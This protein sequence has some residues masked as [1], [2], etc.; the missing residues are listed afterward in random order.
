MEPDRF[1][2]APLLKAFS[3]RPSFDNEL[4]P[5]PCKT[6]GVTASKPMRLQMKL[7]P[8]K[9]CLSF[10]Y[11]W[12]WGISRDAPPPPPEFVRMD[13]WTFARSYTDVITKFSR[14]DG[15]PIFLTHG[16]S[17]VRFAHWSFAKMFF[18]LK[19]T[20]MLK[21]SG[22]WL[23]KNRLLWAHNFLQPSVCFL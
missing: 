2:N 15:L 6:K 17:L 1:E 4:E 22:W 9:Q 18:K 7:C 12:P 13:G 8:C 19:I 3:K 21:S 11:G 14:L 16:A 5:A 20:T 10:P 23:E